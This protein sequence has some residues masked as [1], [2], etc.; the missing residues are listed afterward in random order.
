MMINKYFFV[1]IISFKSHTY[2]N[3]KIEISDILGHKISY[4]KYPE[5]IGDFKSSHSLKDYDSGIY[6]VKIYI[7]NKLIVRKITLQ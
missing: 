5:F 7:E 6:I 4:R 2:Q 1:F 3:I